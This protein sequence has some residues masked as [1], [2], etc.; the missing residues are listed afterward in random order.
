MLDLRRRKMQF[1]VWP[2]EGRLTLL[3]SPEC[4]LC[5][6]FCLCLCVPSYHCHH[7]R[8]PAGCWRTARGQKRW[9]PE[10]ST[11]S[12]GNHLSSTCHI[13]Q[14]QTQTEKHVTDQKKKDLDCSDLCQSR[15]R[16]RCWTLPGAAHTSSRHH[17]LW[18]DC[19][20]CVRVCVIR[21]E[22]TWMCV[23]NQR[24]GISFSL[25]HTDGRTVLPLLSLSEGI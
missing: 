7:R 11:E 13:L 12:S 21:G 3:K 25:S 23:C 22:F 24:R 15:E 6:H 5:V 4:I 18:Q 14:G 19:D 20:V 2:L 8:R 17:L 1:H 10:S 9:A 16:C